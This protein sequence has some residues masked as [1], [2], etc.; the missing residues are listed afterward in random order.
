MIMVN[1]MNNDAMIIDSRTGE[2][3]H[4]IKNAGGGL[5]TVVEPR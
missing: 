5:I 2:V 4:T 3:K 1:G